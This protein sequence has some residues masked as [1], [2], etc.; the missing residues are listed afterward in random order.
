MRGA[1][2]TSSA[3]IRIASICEAAFASLKVPLRPVR[4]S[5]GLM[6]GNEVREDLGRRRIFL[7]D[8]RKTTAHRARSS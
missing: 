2:P 5:V 3:Q 4:V 8:S 1:V 6:D 7:Y